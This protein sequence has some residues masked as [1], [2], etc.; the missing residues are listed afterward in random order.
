MPELNPELARWAL[1]AVLLLTFLA[2][3]WYCPPAPIGD[4]EDEEGW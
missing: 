1:G 4:E 2:I 3:A